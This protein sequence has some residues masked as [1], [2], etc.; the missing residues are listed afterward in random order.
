MHSGQYLNVQVHNNIMNHSQDVEAVQM[1]I[2]KALDKQNLG[3]TDT[4]G[5][6]SAPQKE[7]GKVGF[8][9]VVKTPVKMPASHIIRPRF[10]F[11]PQL[12][13]PSCWVPVM[14]AGGPDGAPT[15]QFQPSLA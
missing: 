10:N 4:R 7:Q 15:S 14:E 5:Y 9:L 1:P 8:D 3:Y 13:I 6:Y 12:P 11:C 2:S